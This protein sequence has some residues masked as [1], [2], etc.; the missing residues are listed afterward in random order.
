MDK[1]EAEITCPS[2]KRKFPQRVEDMVPG[3]SGSCP[4]CRANIQWTGD[5]GRKA[6]KAIDDL[7]KTIRDL[8]RGRP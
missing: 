6:Q 4:N 5:D 1:L 7:K 8:N 2:C 3:R